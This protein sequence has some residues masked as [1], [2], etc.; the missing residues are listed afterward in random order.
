MNNSYFD[1]LILFLVFFGK[2]KVIYQNCDVTCL[3]NNR[4]FLFGQESCGSELD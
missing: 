1:Y 2:V 4:K 3:G